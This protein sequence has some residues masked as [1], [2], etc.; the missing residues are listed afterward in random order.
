VNAFSKVHE[1][2]QSRSAFVDPESGTTAIYCNGERLYLN[3]N[4][5]SWESV[6]SYGTA[7]NLSRI[8]DTTGTVDHAS[9]VSMPHDSTTVQ[10]DGNLS[11][12]QGQVWVMRYGNWLIVGNPTATAATIKLPAGQGVARDLVNSSNYTLSS[13]GSSFSLAAGKSVAINMPIPV[14]CQMIPNGT[15]VLTQLSSG[16]VLNCPNGSNT[17][18]LQITQSTPP[19]GTSPNWVIT[20]TDNGYYTVKNAASGFYL[21]GSNGSGGGNLVQEAADGE[22]DQLW[23]LVPDDTGYSF[24]NNQSGAD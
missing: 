13:S 14:T 22:S 12:T 17:P 11:G 2:H 10:S 24:A 8:H 16:L 5:R 23:Q 15:Y 4:W 21:T 20:Y 19:G 6:N 7:D 3:N 9:L 18:G 1:N